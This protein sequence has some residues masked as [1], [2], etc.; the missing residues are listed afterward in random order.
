MFRLLL[1]VLQQHQSVAF[2]PQRYC[3]TRLVHHGQIGIQ[4]N[5]VNVTHNAIFS[6]HFP[7]ALYLYRLALHKYFKSIQ[8]HTVIHVRPYSWNERW[9]WGFREKK[10]LQTEGYSKPPYIHS[11]FLIASFHIVVDRKQATRVMRMITKGWQETPYNTRDLFQTLPDTG[12]EILDFTTLCRFERYD[13]R[14]SSSLSRLV[15]FHDTLLYVAVS[16]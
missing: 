10:H 12:Y 5:L 1:T 11:V 15:R 13:Q 9:C 8:S 7:D 3:C 14:L 16:Q 4:V 6:V 2:L